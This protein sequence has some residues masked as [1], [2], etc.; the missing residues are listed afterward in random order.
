MS[1]SSADSLG[2]RYQGI[3]SVLTAVTVATVN[4]GKTYSAVKL[5]FSNNDASVGC[6]ASVYLV[7]SGQSATLPYR[8]LPPTLIPAG[9]EME[10]TC[11]HEL[12]AGFTIQVI[13]SVI[14]LLTCMCS[15]RE[16]S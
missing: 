8:I 7:P 12:P 3:L 5:T 9:V 14:N 11:P 10:Y 16:L 1:I 6:L 13:A 2:I 4:T 15:A